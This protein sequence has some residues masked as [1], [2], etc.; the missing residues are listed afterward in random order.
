MIFFQQG[1][2]VR[3]FADDPTP[4]SEVGLFWNFSEIC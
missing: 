2:M 3:E 4:D 1:E